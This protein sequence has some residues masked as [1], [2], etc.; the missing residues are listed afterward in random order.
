MHESFTSIAKALS[1]ACRIHFAGDM[2][3]QMIKDNDEDMI[4]LFF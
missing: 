2:L 4:Y 1:I 3:L